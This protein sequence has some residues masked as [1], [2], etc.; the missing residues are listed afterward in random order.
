VL[1]AAGVWGTVLAGKYGAWTAGTSAAFVYRSFV[2]G[3]DHG[4]RAK[5][6]RPLPVPAGGRSFW[7]DP[8]PP[9]SPLLHQSPELRLAAVIRNALANSGRAVTTLASGLTP[10]GLA[11]LFV[12]VALLIRRRLSR[13]QGL[14]LV[15]VI[16]WVVGYTLALVESRYYWAVFPPLWA[17]LCGGLCGR[18]LRRLSGRLSARSVRAIQIVLVAGVAAGTAF[19]LTRRHVEEHR[20]S[21]VART[22]VA[23]GG[24]LRSHGAAGGA[25]LLTDDWRFGL[26][27]AYHGGP[28]VRFAGV[29]SAD[30]HERTGDWLAAARDYAERHR[31]SADEPW[32]AC[33]R[34]PAQQE[35]TSSEARPDGRWRLLGTVGEGENRGQ[36]YLLLPRTRRRPPPSCE[37]PPRVLAVAAAYPMPRKRLMATSASARTLW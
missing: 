2:L 32:F 37:G 14:V 22:A 4:V 29:L 1:A 35:P 21:A 19:S 3:E 18:G 31:N 34:I 20:S 30:T 23:A 16:L 36:I 13:P 5:N 10:M 27:A 8:V 9:G 6:E 33:L 26:Y 12:P 7:S 17:L 11:A 15:L 28:D 25:S 24:I